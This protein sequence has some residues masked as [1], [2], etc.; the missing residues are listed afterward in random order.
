MKANEPVLNIAK[1]I[2][3][4]MGL[5]YQTNRIEEFSRHLGE[6]VLTLGYPDF[7]S[8][9]KKIIISGG[10]L[11]SEEKKVLAA[12]LTVSETYFFREKPAITMFCKTIIPELIKKKNGEIIRI[13]SAGCSSGEE[14]YTLAMI[15]KE[16]FPALP[17]DSF[18]ILGTDINPNVLTKARNGLYTPWSF[19]EIPDLYVNKYFNKIGD[20]YQITDSL[21]DLVKFEHLNL[22]DDI[23]PGELPGE[24]SID[25]I[26][27]R[28]VL[29]YLNHELIKKISQRFYNILNESGWLITSQ[30]ELNDA[31]F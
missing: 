14:P 11:S 28:N 31:F 22:A 18:K 2:E 19:R 6:A 24:P 9:N 12:H 30:V 21:R 1:V 26:F 25:I 17:K 4:S 20:N 8:F 15:I 27:C 29:M 3:S 16:L 23:F 10:K 5:A 7:E 13:W